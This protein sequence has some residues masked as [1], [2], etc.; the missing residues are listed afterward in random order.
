MNS[1][2]SKCVHVFSKI[3]GNKPR[4]QPK[5]EVTVVSS[6]RS[7]FDRIVAWDGVQYTFETPGNINALAYSIT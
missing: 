3:S 1:E 4:M 7:A 2:T 6:I 5:C